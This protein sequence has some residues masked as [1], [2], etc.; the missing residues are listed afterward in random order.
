[1]SDNGRDG[2]VQATA[3]EYDVLVI[4][5][6]LPGLDGLAV[7]ETLRK[8]G[9]ETPVLFLSAKGRV[10]DR[11]A[12]LKA[13]ADDYLVKPFSVD[14]LLARLRALQRRRWE[15]EQPKPDE[16]LVLGGLSLN[17]TTETASLAG[18]DL[19]LLKKEY[20]LLVELLRA[21]GEPYEAEAL[22][23]NLWGEAGLAS[24]TILDV[25]VESVQ[26]KLSSDDSSP[27]LQSCT[28]QA[29]CLL[30]DSGVSP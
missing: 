23:L 11:V 19:P 29:W 7:V 18:A 30:E 26:Q 28:D 1:M 20:D 10:D 22:L 27:R 12:G 3:G 25:Y 14:E 9:Q 8:T 21:D 13:G 15:A 4:D 17:L 6:M 2:L 5:R 24:P 16:V